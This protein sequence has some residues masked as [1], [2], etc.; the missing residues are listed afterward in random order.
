[1]IRETPS[2]LREISLVYVAT[3]AIAVGISALSVVPLLGDLQNVLIGLL[4]LL[5]ALRMAQREHQ[6]TRRYGIDLGGVLAPPAEDS[7]PGFLA[8]FR[9][10]LT[11]VRGALPA[12]HLQQRH[13]VDLPRR[14]AVCHPGRA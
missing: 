9:E 5:T 2:V 11:V 7:R 6:G 13:G 3:T 8:G 10:L 14:G 1:M 4:F 12:A